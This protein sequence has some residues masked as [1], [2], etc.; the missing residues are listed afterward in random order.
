MEIYGEYR[1]MVIGAIRISNISTNI[2]FKP[3]PQIS[4]VIKPL[5]I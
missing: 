1:D 5:K 3:L 4:E 2:L